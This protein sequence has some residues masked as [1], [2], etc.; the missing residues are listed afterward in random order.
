MLP[1]LMKTFLPLAIALLL[2]AC[3]SEA[4]V[5]EEPKPPT[6]A[7]LHAL[8]SNRVKLLNKK[9]GLVKQLDKIVAQSKTS[10]SGDMNLV[11]EER[12]Q[13]LVDLQ[14]IRTTHPNLQKLNEE[15]TFWQGN[16]R[17]ARSSDRS[18]ELEQATQQIAEITNKIHTLSRELPAI[19]EAEDNIARTEKEI[20]ALRRSL[21]EQTPEGKVLMDELRQIEEELS[22]P[23]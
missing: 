18:A 13:A 17:R 9:M 7:Q 12:Q 19:R 22:S 15:L 10:S 16:L 20:S 23:Q 21:A 14:T 3:K 1:F 8:H 5:P 2:A 6:E 4:P 11:L